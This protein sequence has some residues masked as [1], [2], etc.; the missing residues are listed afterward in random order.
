[1]LKDLIKNYKK[2]AICGH[3]KPD[4]DC[5]GSTLTVYNYIKK[6]T[7]KH[8]DIFLEPISDSYS[9]LE[10]YDKIKHSYEDIGYDL[11]IALDCGDSNRIGVVEFNKNIDSIC[12]DHH[13]SNEGFATTNIIH[14]NAAATCEILFDLIPKNELDK[15]LA[16]T[17][18]LGIIHDTGVFRYTNTS[19]KTFEIAG[20]LID[21]NI[22]SNKIINETFEEKSYSSNLLLGKMLQNSKLYLNNKVIVGNITKQDFIDYKID[23]SDLD[24]FVD[25]I[26]ITKGVL[27][28]CF[29]YPTNT[30]YKISLRSNKNTNVSVIASYFG[31]GGHIKAA[32]Y[33]TNTTDYDIVL[34]TL[35]NK[36]QEYLE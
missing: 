18:Y 9:F 11:I 19:K 2:I 31:G 22:D 14:P 6:Y 8:A 30:G 3:K 10:N 32:G 5:I 21:L 24:G 16:E 13:I 28:A 35:L 33:N 27:V 34:S 26:R 12:I 25:A 23:S 29:I 15:S 36:I 17:I 4:G 1:M 20:I 7:N